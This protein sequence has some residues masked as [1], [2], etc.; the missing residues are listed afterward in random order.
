MKPP[1]PP[2]PSSE[3][4]AS[5]LEREALIFRLQGEIVALKA[6]VLALRARLEKKA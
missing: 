2:K 6:Q 4:A 3:I 1:L 5:L